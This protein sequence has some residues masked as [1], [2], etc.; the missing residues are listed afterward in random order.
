MRRFLLVPAVLGLAVSL[1]AQSS[2]PSDSKPPEDPAPDL[3]T[4][5]GRVV[6]AADGNPLKS[7]RVAL[8]PEHNRSHHE[9]IYATSSDSDGHF[10]LK[11]IPQGRYRFFAAHTGFV[12][13]HYK[14]GVGGT[15]PLFSLRPGEK[16]NDV[17]FRL[18]AAAVITGRVSNEDG[19][20][21]QRVEVTALRRPSEEEVE[22]D[23]VPRPHKA[24]M[25]S[26]GAAESDD[27]GQYRIFGLKPGEYFVKAEDSSRPIG[28]AVEQDESFWLKLSYGSEYA[29]VYYP[30]VTQVS[31]AQVVPI[32]AGEEAGAD[33]T[34]RRVKTV[35]VSGRVIGATGP[36][37]NSF[38]SLQPA[39]SSAS[40]FDRQDTTDEKGNF[41]LRNVPEGTYYLLAFQREEGTLVYESR[42]RQKIEVGG[43][44]LDG[45]TIS[46]G[47]GITIPGRVKIDSSSSVTFDRLGLS[48]TPVDEDSQLGGHS[49]VK[50]DGSFEFKSVHDGG[51]ALS[52]WGLEN[53]AYVRSVRRGPDDV[54]EKGVQVEGN[55]SGRL[56][57]TLGSDGAKLEGSVSDDDGAVI[58]ARVR[59]VPDPLTPYNRLRIHST[60]TDQLGHFTLTDI[61]PGKY[62]LTAK[63]VVSSETPGYKAEPQA[64][65][66]AENDHKTAEIKLEKPQE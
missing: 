22:D 52:V 8:V 51:Y 36:A 58:G 28:R 21:M 23:D 63:P 43:D 40:G 45:I 64:I 47:G 49:E 9:E 60:T 25:Q 54:L 3:C 4:V 26:V 18:I 53:G 55:S 27:R 46:L 39:D 56:E 14:A 57:V 32:K 31:Q 6:A 24:Q 10:T 35:E 41:R 37:A 62:K 44:N 48:L 12:Q 20:P 66:L 17:L 50:K 65:T 38:V 33:I 19:D 59:L 7:A 29:P 11:N 2:A 13:Q 30:G 1:L 15:A 61:A 42:A 34:M 5:M 16:V